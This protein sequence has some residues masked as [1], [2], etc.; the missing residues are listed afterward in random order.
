MGGVVNFKYPEGVVVHYRYRGGVEN[1]NALRQNGGTKFQ[2]FLES[3][4]GTTWY[5]FQVFL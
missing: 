2:M 1:H 4:R 3:S 5:S